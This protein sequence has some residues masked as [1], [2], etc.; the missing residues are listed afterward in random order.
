MRI[1]SALK[2]RRLNDY[3]AL[4]HKILLTNSKLSPFPL[5]VFILDGWLGLDMK[6]FST[7][8]V[9]LIEEVFPQDTNSYNT[10]FGGRLL[11]VMDKAAGIACSKFAH[12]EFV[13]ISID[14]L[15]FKAPARQGDLIEV[16]GRVV[17]T[18]TH[19]AGVKVT[20]CA[21]TKSDWETRVICEGYFF[22]VA[23]DSMMRPIPIP[24]LVP[25]S[26][27]GLQ[28]WKKAEEIRENMLSKR[29]SE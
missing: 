6:P 13:T 27:E 24:Q 7:E 19:T 18:S 2:P 21:M 26:E 23:I 8:P 16:T 14:T 17:F 29:N 20:A 12:R 28:E 10:L 4:K 3:N 15:T 1:D 22:M 25:E 11:S 5:H 9:M